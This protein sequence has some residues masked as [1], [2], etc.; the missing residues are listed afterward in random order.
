MK[1][2]KV[3]ERKDAKRKRDRIKKKRKGSMEWQRRWLITG[4]KTLG[5]RIPEDLS[6][7]GSIG[8]KKGA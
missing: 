8:N 7:L 3:E 4:G 5:S 6:L 2:L 1:I